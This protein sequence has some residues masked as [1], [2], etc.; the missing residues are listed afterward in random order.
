MNNYPMKQ[1]DSVSAGKPWG[2]GRLTPDFSGP[3]ASR[4]PESE[5][6]K[7]AASRSVFR[8]DSTLLTIEY[9]NNFQEV[10]QQNSS[11]RFFFF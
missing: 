5:T 11:T 1:N 4:N 9:E 3:L 2:K 7:T 8:T 6:Q 10:N